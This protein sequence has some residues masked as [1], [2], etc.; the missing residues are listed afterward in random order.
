MQIATRV[1]DEMKMTAFASNASLMPSGALPNPG[2]GN[3]SLHDHGPCKAH[4][5]HA[6]VVHYRWAASGAILIT[7]SPY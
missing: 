1:C 6:K 4:I 3:A 7:P 5:L 2:S